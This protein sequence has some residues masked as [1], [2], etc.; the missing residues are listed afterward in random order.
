MGAARYE[1]KLEA[2]MNTNRP[3]SFA[4]DETSRETVILPP[5]QS[6]GTLDCKQWNCRAFTAVSQG[7][8]VAATLTVERSADSQMVGKVVSIDRVP[9]TLGRQDCDLTFAGA[10]GVSRQHAQITLQDGVLFIADI[11]SMNHTFIDECVL[12]SNVPTPLHDGT[13]IRLGSFT[14]LNLALQE[15]GGNRATG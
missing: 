15:R 4:N 14:V 10:P 9:F 2:R 3:H 5:A 12:P 13:T 1:Y 11:E 7:P 6:A 8:I